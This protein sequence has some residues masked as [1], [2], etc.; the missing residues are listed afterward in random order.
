MSK[1]FARAALL[2]AAAFCLSQPA[3]AQVRVNQLP[4]GSVNG[5]YLTLCD[6][7][8]TTSA[9]TF[10]QL[11]AYFQAN[12]SFPTWQ[13]P[14]GGTGTSS[15]SGLIRGNGTSPFTSAGASDIYSLFTGPC[16]GL[17]FLRGDGVCA[18]PSGSGN[19][20]T[21]GSPTN[22]NLTQ[23]SGGT[24][25]TNANLSG[26][27]TTAG[28][29][30]L[31]CTKTNGVNFGTF[32]TQN[33]TTPPAIGAVTP[34]A[35]NFTTLTA[36]STLT[37]NVT[38]SL[39]C[40]HAN[41]SGVVSGTGVDCG[42]GG[43]GGGSFT[44]ITGGSNS[45]AAMVMTSGASLSTSG[46]G[47]IQ[48]TSVSALAGLPSIATQTILGNGSGSTV[49]PVALTVAGNLVVTPTGFTT[50]QP[51]NPQVG[52]SYTINSGDAGK[53][54]TLSNASAIGVTLPQAGT[55]G[56]T[57]GFSFDIENIGAGTVTLT[58]TT[59]TIDGAASI[60]IQTHKG[61]TVSSDNT[62][63]QVSA[64]T[65]VFPGSAASFST[66]TSGTNSAMAGVIG[67]GASLTVSGTG[68]NNAN[69][70]NALAVPIN[71]EKLTTNSGGQ[72]VAMNLV[73]D[74]P[75]SSVN[76]YAPAGFTV[77]TG[78]LYLTPSSGGTTLTGLL[79]GNNL[80]EVYII[81]AQAAGGADLIKLVNQSASST[82]ANRFL[83]SA[84]VS[85]A[86]PPGGRVLCINLPSVTRWSCQ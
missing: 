21:T 54:I 25:I 79:A 2:L 68:T 11:A 60:T 74:S 73:S 47:T 28:A 31:T 64:C 20:S 82:A 63:Y 85:L 19:V 5:T 9:C 66:L 84:T 26:D 39:Q 51:L 71:A 49:P 70:V 16:T 17:T 80:Q 33:F 10:N 23:F 13:V 46:T 44:A 75:A 30:A 58:P 22:G 69:Q 42:S 50:S 34:A 76:D 12:L 67:S 43:G 40:L 15:I 61:C 56:F 24:T 29:L 35:A 3:T 57:T 4:I 62:N 18:T 48:A 53:L 7:L 32:A 81:N 55:T 37:T 77:A 41:S 36:S 6:N 8:T 72:L 14:A 65:A 38:G 1:H 78:V 59:S 45:T 27:C 83:T 86:I 52:T